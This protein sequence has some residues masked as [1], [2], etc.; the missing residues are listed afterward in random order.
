ME[1]YIVKMYT[2]KKDLEGKIKR[3][4]AAL[5]NKSLRLQPYQID[6]MKRQL[7]AMEDYCEILTERIAFENKKNE[8]K[9]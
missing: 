8:Q 5:E 9:R 4:K 3:L 2:E 7:S 1:N 6:V